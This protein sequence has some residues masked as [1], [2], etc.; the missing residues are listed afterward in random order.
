[1]TTSAADRALGPDSDEAAATP[2]VLRA[3][4]VILHVSF[5]GLLG[6]AVGR[7][8]IGASC[9]AP[10]GHPAEPVQLSGNPTL[11]SRA[12]DGR[13]EGRRVTGKENVR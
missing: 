4:R 11:P 7:F 9:P 8:L 6:L 13:P 12:S 5:A 2:A 3:M 10:C 1:M